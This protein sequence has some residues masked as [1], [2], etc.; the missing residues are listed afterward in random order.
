MYATHHSQRSSDKTVPKKPFT[1]SN[2]H[3]RLVG[4]N[5]ND[6]IENKSHNATTGIMMIP[7]INPTN[8]IVMVD[9]KVKKYNNPVT[10]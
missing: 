5:S 3:T 9:I 10:I 6:S 7:S 8:P 2:V 1:N 4:G